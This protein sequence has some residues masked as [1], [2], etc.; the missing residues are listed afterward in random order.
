MNIGW[1]RILVLMLLVIVIIITSCTINSTKDDISSIPSIEESNISLP[2]IPEDTSIE[3][4]STED[5]A[6]MF[7]ASYTYSYYYGDD[8]KKLET[9]KAYCEKRIEEINITIQNLQKLGYED[10]YLLIEFLNEDLVVYTDAIQYYEE[11]L[12]EVMKTMKQTMSVSV[13]MGKEAQ[14][15]IWFYLRKQGFNAHVTAGII[16]NLTAESGCNPINLQNSAS[17]RIG[18]TDSEYTIAVDTNT[19]RNFIYDSAGYG[20]AQW[21]FSGHKENL[22]ALAKKSNASVG[23]IYIQLEYLI[24]SMKRAFADN[25]ES[26]LNLKDEQEAAAR[27]ML[28][29]EKPKNKD[30]TARRKKATEIYN[31]FVG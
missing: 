15:I 8:Y 24:S 22:L 29:Y 12:Q 6:I 4:V 25:Y 18:L 26:F 7:P 30:T 13:P 27:F 5:E 10:N 1:T 11:T 19:Y 14:T 16:A 31:S 21:T 2:E 23:N 20:L 28:V 9:E 17:K 3:E